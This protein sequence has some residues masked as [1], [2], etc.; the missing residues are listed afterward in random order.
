[1][2]QL[3]TRLVPDL[4]PLQAQVQAVL[5]HPEVLD[6]AGRSDAGCDLLLALLEPEEAEGVLRAFSALRQACGEACYLP[7][8]RLR[9]WLE[10]AVE[11]RVGDGEWRSC[12]LIDPDFGR[13]L[14]RA[15]NFCWEMDLS[16]ASPSAIPVEFRWQA[17]LEARD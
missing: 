4:L 15:R 3:A 13:T 17:H 10:T 7:L 11:M 5:L 1:M 12:S 2:S 6:H 8:F 16:Q 9:R 14:R